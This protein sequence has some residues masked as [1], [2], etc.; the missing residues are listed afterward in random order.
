M[1]PIP[2]SVR[3][4]GRRGPSPRDTAAPDRSPRCPG[5]QYEL[6]G[7]RVEDRCPECGDPVWTDI[8]PRA[9]ELGRIYARAESS[10]YASVLAIILSIGCGPFGLLVAV[11][12]TTNSLLS[13]RDRSMNPGPSRNM[14]FIS[15]AISLIAIGISAIWVASMFI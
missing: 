10:F 11:W 2:G 6:T 8:E 13:I 7:L 9:I 12:S 3:R 15:L 5:C 4:T 14:P 1:H